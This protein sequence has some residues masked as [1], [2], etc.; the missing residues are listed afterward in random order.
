MF[1]SP[2][3]WFLLIVFLIQCGT[4]Y[5]G[6]VEGVA[7]TQELG[8]MGTR[9]L[10]VL[11]DRIFLG[12]GGIFGSVM[13]NLYLYIPLLTMS[14]I[15]RETSSGTIKLL[16]SSPI[17]VRDIIFGKYLAMIACSLLLVA[18]VSIF[19]VSGLF[20][21][22]H[23]E[24]GMLLTALFGFFL[25]LCAYS[26]I[27]LFMSC[28]TTYQVVA[29]ISTF[30]MIGILSYIGTLWQRIAFVRELAYFLSISGRTQK[31]LRGLITTKDVIY[32]M[33]IVYI[34]LGF[35]IYRL[36]SGMESKSTLIK[37]SRYIV[38]MVSALI[39]G[40]VSSIPGLIGYFDATANKTNTITP[41]VQK[42]VADFGEEPLEI[43][44]YVNL[45]D[46]YAYLG[47]P[48][49]YNDNQARWENYMRFK[50]NI[51]LKIVSYYDNPLNNSWFW[52]SYPGK[53]LKEIA[54]QYAK[55][56][57]V[58]LKDYL[59]PEQINKQVDLKPEGNRYVM[60]LK[61]KG[62]TTFLRVFDDQIVWPMETEVAAAM[63]R[64]QQAKMPLI[65]FVT[66]SLERDIDKAGDREYKS[67]T[68]LHT[69][70]NSLINQGFDVQTVSLDS[71]DIP[72]G[73]AAVVLAD[74]KIEL[75]PSETAKLKQYIQD[76]GNLLIAGEP[77]KRAVLNPLLKELGVQLIDG[78]LVQESKDYSPDMVDTWVTPAATP[79]YKPLEKALAD[80][81][82][83][84]MPGVAA[85][86]YTTSG[87]FTVHPLVLT[88]AKKTW[89]R[90]KPVD[91]E[92]MIS[93]S[94]VRSDT[95]KAAIGSISYSA[96]DGDSKGPFPTVISLTRQINHKEQRII[97][98]GDADF[99]SNKEIGR[100]GKSNFMF[101]TALFSWLNNG[102]FPI[103]AF[104]PESKDRR[105]F[106]TID[107]VGVL[108]IIYVW[109]LPA[110][111][112]ALAAI[113]LIRRK[114]K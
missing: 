114:R 1:Y 3:A 103:N 42:I 53:N 76:G 32:F 45:L 86:S 113:I 89:N 30:V 9:F 58:S 31:M 93:A 13:Q 96:A 15:S 99:L 111:L 108:R 22:Q 102:A 94:A 84:F 24:T 23:A 40:Y 48:A 75:S 57:S 11:T 97:V 18:I 17:K 56:N 69:F 33:V 8:R 50:P 110:L 34:F 64:L 55:S 16:Y 112:L 38:I 77:A 101:N 2:I 14:L 105:V 52:K 35:S 88:D 43:T 68:N 60:Q 98:A 85:L 20:H 83:V 82:P 78:M 65:A 51:K 72:A 49:S 19:V 44:A 67:L 46:Q 7:R 26:A 25:L 90:I 54:E 66:G 109:V 27:G 95:G 4:A 81:M 70:R 104:R 63:K 61:W 12:N 107:Q 39:I 6:M 74:P 80:S 100:W 29:A 59:T 37:A 79:F 5:L 92:L 91:P 10:S 28:L 73:V 87:P 41:N 36:K 21:I 106:L 62:R 47:G 71:M